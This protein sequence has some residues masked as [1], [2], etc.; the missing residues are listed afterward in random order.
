[1]HIKEIMNFIGKSSENTS[2]VERLNEKIRQLTI[3]HDKYMNDYIARYDESIK[4]YDNLRNQLEYEKDRADEI[5]KRYKNVVLLIKQYRRIISLFDC[6]FEMQRAEIAQKYSLLPLPHKPA[7]FTDVI[8]SIMDR[9]IED[10][11][12]MDY[13]SRQKELQQRDE[14]HKEFYEL[15]NSNS[16]YMIHSIFD[17]LEE[18][19][20]EKTPVPI[21]I[22]F[23][24]AKKHGLLTILPTPLQIRNHF[25]IGESRYK[26]LHHYEE[27]DVYNKNT[28]KK[29]EVEQIEEKIIEFKNSSLF[30]SFPK[31][32]D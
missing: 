31:K 29:H 1:M 18:N 21:Q 9:V 23:L 8:A 3:Q 20:K 15:I 11:P 13:N 12:V 2:E 14:E 6:N 7:I 16:D 26:N 24:L 30:F 10:N 19:I 27:K 32:T 17:F 5:E 22:L 4:N 28:F 25:K